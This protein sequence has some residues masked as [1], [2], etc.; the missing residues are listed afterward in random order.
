MFGSACECVA[1]SAKCRA[2]TRVL[3][4][5]DDTREDDVQAQT[6]P[7]FPFC[8]ILSHVMFAWHVMA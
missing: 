5:K 7:G 2:E 4:S 3:H 8:W 6:G 1:G